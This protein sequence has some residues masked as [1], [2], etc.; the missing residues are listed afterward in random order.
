MDNT[1][2]VIDGNTNETLST[3]T[4]DSPVTMMVLNP[5]RN[6]AYLYNDDK[7]KLTVL[8]L[9]TNKP[10]AKIGIHA[11]WCGLAI[12]PVTDRVYASINNGIGIVAGKTNSLIEEVSLGNMAAYCI[13][14]N[15]V[16]NQL[17]VSFYNKG[18]DGVVKAVSE[19]THSVIATIPVG[20]GPL[21]IAAN[22]TT[23]Q[24]YVCNTADDTVSV[25]DGMANTVVAT[26]PVLLRN[27]RP[28]GIAVNP[29][30]NR[31]Y[32]ANPTMKTVTVIDGNAFLTDA[33]KK[34]AS[35][36][37]T[38]TNGVASKFEESFLTEKLDL[39][40]WIVMG[41]E[42]FSGSSIDIMKRNDAKGS[43][44][45]GK[46]DL[47]EIDTTNKKDAKGSLRMRLD[48]KKSN[49]HFPK[50]HG[51][52]T[53][54]TVIDFDKTTEVSYIFYWSNNANADNMTSCVYLSPDKPRLPQNNAQDYLAIKY[55]GNPYGPGARLEVCARVDGAIQI[56]YDENYSANPDSFEYREIARQQIRLNVDQNKIDVWENEKQ[57]CYFEF[58]NMKKLNGP[59]PWSPAY[60]YIEQKCVANQSAPQEVFFSDIKI[61]Q[62]PVQ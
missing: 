38:P 40:R 5:T 11:S 62:I 17:Y 49:D 14:M 52:R 26:V 42:N 32:V 25:L 21:G 19:K 48:M 22:P 2:N 6:I 43:L 61:N 41:N 15:P 4:V 18:Q 28:G 57:I 8:D 33:G 55:C 7:Y 39:S 56:I 59:L 23:N 12:N 47:Q 24:I 31:V 29:V 34:Y 46:V 51:V 30:T 35:I 44:W 27:I 45:I 54:D 36:M 10:I 50:T 60:L 16:T 9:I 3:V 58:R 1:I 53:Q 20:N 37:H 13:A